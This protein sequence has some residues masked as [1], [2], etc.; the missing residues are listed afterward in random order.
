MIAVQT[1]VAPRFEQCA[2][3]EECRAGP[4]PLLPRETLLEESVGTTCP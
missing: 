3:C 1:S 4:Q 2:G